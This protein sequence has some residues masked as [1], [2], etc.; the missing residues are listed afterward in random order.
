VISAGHIDHRQSNNEP[1]LDFAVIKLAGASGAELWR[2]EISGT[3][4]LVPPRDL[5]HA[6]AVDPSGDVLAA[7]I[8]TNFNFFYQGQDFAVVRLDGTTGAIEWQ[9][10]LQGASTVQGVADNGLAVAGDATGAAIAAGFLT[11]ATSTA[12]FAVVRLGALDGAVGPVRGT[13]LTVRDRAG[14]ATAQV[15]IAVADDRAIVAPALGSAG[16]P[17]LYGAGLRLVNPGTLETASIPLPSLHWAAIADGGFEYRDRGTSGPCTIVR[18][19]PRKQIKARCT[20]RFG[21][22]PFS[23]DEPSQGTL[24]V[25]LQLGGAERQCAIMGGV[26][27]VVRDVGITGP[28]T[29][30]SFRARRANP[31]SADCP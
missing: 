5:A 12:D 14:D 13:K 16:D 11:N 3:T 9:Q 27:S 26:V 10:A 28:T 20:G 19:R 22:I 30:G 15:L 18:V 17:T 21:T 6:V 24:A 2:R 7:G 1:D 4:S 31:P 25:S 23:L 29:T 8:V